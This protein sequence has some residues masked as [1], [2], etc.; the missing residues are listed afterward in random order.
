L[1]A[2]GGDA[3]GADFGLIVDNRVDG[4]WIEAAEDGGGHGEARRA[5]VRRL[6]GLG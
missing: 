5:A 3:E 4:R 2:S 6:V 1:A